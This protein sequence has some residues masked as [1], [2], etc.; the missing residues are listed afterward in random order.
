MK[1][2]KR[3]W[4]SWIRWSILVFL[5]HSTILGIIYG[6]D[7]FSPREFIVDFNNSI[8]PWFKIITA[9]NYL[10]RVF[11]ALIIPISTFSL[12]VLKR[13]G[14]EKDD[15]YEGLILLIIGGVTTILSVGMFSTSVLGFGALILLGLF[16][17]A[18]SFVWWDLRSGIIWILLYS[19]VWGLLPGLALLLFFIFLII[20]KRLLLLNIWMRIFNW[21]MAK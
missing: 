21:L 10:P 13:K 17:G 19:L 4:T 11:D 12:L 5:V 15:R 7:I 6:S 2:Q 8:L 20:I 3:E 16:I 14:E 1:T 9:S 18:M